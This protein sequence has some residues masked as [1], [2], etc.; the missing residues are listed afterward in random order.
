MTNPTGEEILQYL[1]DAGEA[2]Q[3]KVQWG[4]SGYRNVVIFQGKKYLYKGTGKINKR[5]LKSI[6]PL[7][8]SMSDKPS[9]KNTKTSTNNFDVKLKFDKDV[10]NDRTW[11]NKDTFT[12]FESEYQQSQDD[13]SLSDTSSVEF[14]IHIKM[15]KVETGAEETK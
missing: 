13:S 6:L 4:K 8:I 10:D 1:L 5:L 3:A 14:E 2:S 11:V 9:N 7:Y 12:E 15:K